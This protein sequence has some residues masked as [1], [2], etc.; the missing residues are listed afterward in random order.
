MKPKYVMSFLSVS[1]RPRATVFRRAHLS[2]NP[3]SEE[4][5]PAVDS[6]FAS[7]SAVIAKTV[8]TDENVLASTDIGERTPGISLS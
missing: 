8:V 2:F 4:R 1:I 5:H 7:Q 6:V 3:L